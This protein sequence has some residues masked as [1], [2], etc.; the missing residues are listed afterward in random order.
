[1][2]RTTTPR[3]D[4]S[5]FAM[6]SAVIIMAMMATLA[7]IVLANGQHADRTSARG[8]NWNSALHVAEAGVEE[9]VKLL[10]VNLGTPPAAFTGS[11]TDGDYAVEVTALGRNRYRIE[12]VGQVGTVESLATTR[13]LEVVMAPPPSFQYAI[14]SLSDVN[15][16]NTNEIHGDIW[17]NGSVTVYQSDLVEGSV[18]AATG[19]AQLEQASTVT[20][21]VWTGGYDATNN[22]IAVALNATIGGSATAGSTTPG[23][24]DDPGRFAYNITNNGT[25]TGTATAWGNVFGGGTAGGSQVGVCT[26]A[27]VTK[28]IPNFMF[29]ATNYD[30]APTEYASVADFQAWLATGGNRT[31][32]SGVHYVQGSGVI[33]LDGVKIGGDTAVIAPDASIS[34][35]GGQGISEVANG[36]DKVLVLASWYQPPAGSACTTNSGDPLDCAIGIKNNFGPST[37][38]ATLLYAPN[39]P[40]SFKNS[41]DFFGAVY[42][43]DIVLKNNMNLV[44]DERVEQV[45]GFGDVTLQVDAWIEKPV[46]DL[47]VSLAP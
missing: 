33:D 2:N 18:N 5:G 38:T 47:S 22:G 36:I 14:F 12:A 28:A 27:P 25:I 24:T 9:A 7:V 37:D 11:V 16:K 26:A 46:A 45:V 21:D 23:C 39:G 44:Y 15:T 3:P 30:P 35:E 34:A 19:F 17:A 1:M 8:A 4:Q 20:G 43:Q 41:A 32:L 13:G 29:N 42:C 40:C 6:I 10:E 31:N